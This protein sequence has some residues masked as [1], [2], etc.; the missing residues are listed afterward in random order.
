MGCSWRESVLLLPS[1]Y[2]KSCY[3]FKFE[4]RSFHCNFKKQYSFHIIKGLIWNSSSAVHRVPYYILWL[5]FPI[6]ILEKYFDIFFLHCDLCDILK[7]NSTLKDR[8]SDRT[9]H[10]FVKFL[11]WVD[12]WNLSFSIL[13]IDAITLTVQNLHS[14]LK[15]FKYSGQSQQLYSGFVFPTAWWSL[16]GNWNQTS[17]LLN[18]GCLY[19]STHNST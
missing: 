15:S 18:S 8:D 12:S 4:N 9:S 3:Y 11:L 7:G 13:L 6:K 17:S 16:E 2:S 5:L 10:K 1:A 14:C 19:L